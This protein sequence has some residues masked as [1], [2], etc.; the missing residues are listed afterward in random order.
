MTV[1]G[2]L[3]RQQPVYSGGAGT[4]RTPSARWLQDFR[5]SRPDG[6]WL[7]DRRDA[8]P[9]TGT[10][11]PPE[12]R[13]RRLGLSLTA[14]SFE[15]CLSADDDWV[16]VWEDSTEQHYDRSQ[17]IQIHSAL[18]DTVHSRALAA[19]LQTAPSYCDFRLPDT[20][21]GDFT[22]DESG[23]RLSGWITIP[24]ARRGLD[25]YDPLTA[26]TIPTTPAIPRGNHAARPQHG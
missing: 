10:P 12:T 18:V 6:R 8:A 25:A 20:G 7:A 4:R 9:R 2:R 16:T 15:A 23:Y 21:D 19:A 17:D 24:S 1:A 11:A 26:R 3:I 22:I 5:P 14:D 13:D